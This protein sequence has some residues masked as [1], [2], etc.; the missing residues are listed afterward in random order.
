LGVLVRRG[1][2]RDSL[3]RRRAEDTDLIERSWNQSH[4]AISQGAMGARHADWRFKVGTRMMAS[5][6]SPASTAKG[7]RILVVED[8]LMISMLV[9]DMLAELGHKVAG[10]AGSIE[11]A[12]RLAKQGDFDGALLDVNLNGKT[13]DIVV[14]T[15][16]GRNIPIVFTTGYGQQGIPPAY[17]E[18]PTLQKPYQTQQLSQALACAIARRSARSGGST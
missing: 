6:P 7:L 15:L 16:I 13:I 10:I 14:E 1:Y 3:A 5:A 8:E 9:E 11:E 12:A 17:R 4:G 18:W 2:L